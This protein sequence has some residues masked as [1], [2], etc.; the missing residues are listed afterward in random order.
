MINKQLVDFISSQNKIGTNKEVVKKQLLSNGWTNRDIEEAYDNL[1]ASLPS[2]QKISASVSNSN[3]RVENNSDENSTLKNVTIIFAIIALA[4]ALFIVYKEY[5]QSDS[6]KVKDVSYLDQEELQKTN[7]D[8]KVFEQEKIEE[9]VSFD[10]DNEK[11]LPTKDNEIKTTSSSKS[12]STDSVKNSDVLVTAGDQVDLYLNK[13]VILN[14]SNIS[15]F[16]IG[17]TL[18]GVSEDS[19]DEDGRDKIFK[20]EVN[21]INTGESK[22]ITYYDNDFNQNHQDSVFGITIRQISYSYISALMNNGVEQTKLSI[23]VLR[24]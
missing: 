5:T 4:L 18:L 12:Q 9:P 21:K 6:S 23:Q 17:F 3:N 19:N 7:T 2:G 1:N 20:I 11:K 22:I 14:N 10:Q 15:D 8:T 13:K 16:K 24:E